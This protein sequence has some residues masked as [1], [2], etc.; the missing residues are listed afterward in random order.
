MCLLYYYGLY[1][2]YKVLAG[3]FL[4]IGIMSISLFGKTTSA[5][6]NEQDRQS[7]H[8]QQPESNKEAKKDDL[9]KEVD[10]KDAKNEP[11]KPTQPTQSSNPEQAI[12]QPSISPV[13][14]EQP[15][16][17]P[18]TPPKRYLPR[19]TYVPPVQPTPEQTPEVIKPLII[20]IGTPMDNQK[21]PQPEPTTTP[22]ITKAQNLLQYLSSLPMLISQNDQSDTIS[23]EASVAPSPTEKPEDKITYTVKPGETLWQIAESVYGDPYQWQMIAEANNLAHPG[24]IHAGNILTIP[25][26]TAS[27]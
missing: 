2:R 24:T 17:S 26:L 19:R 7:Q 23:P 9:K 14:T 25:P 8:T 5:F 22:L 16:A 27:P 1:M 20:E 11:S 18:T 6:A 21:T 15:V 12:P 10:S 3:L 13:P 4:L